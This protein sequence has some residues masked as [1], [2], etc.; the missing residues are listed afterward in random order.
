MMNM[1]L[2]LVRATAMSLSD[3]YVTELHEIETL[4]LNLQKALQ[5][6]QEGGAE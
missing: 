3:I 5:A 4:H 2:L 6:A 1:I